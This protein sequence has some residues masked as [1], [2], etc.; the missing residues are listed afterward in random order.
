[1]EDPLL[2]Y[3]TNTLLAYRIGQRYYGAEHYVW[4]TPHFDPRSQA[5]LEATVPPS[6]SPAEIY[7]GL[8]EDV[9]RGDLHSDKIEDNRA[10]II[11][12]AKFKQASGLIS[13]EQ[14][15]EILKIADAAVCPDFRPLLYVIPHS[16]VKAILR[17]VPLERR[18]S[19]LSE[20]FVIDRLPRR[21][22]D[23]LELP[24]GN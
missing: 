2:L 9:Q 18:A 20:E 14:A 5:R 7:R 23:V 8:Y 16:L 15:T 22:F 4:C 21:F 11:R 13:A 1:M 3:S 17:E 24:L 12:G 10:G 6:S 19:L